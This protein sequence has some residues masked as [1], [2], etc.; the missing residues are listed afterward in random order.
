LPADDQHRWADHLTPPR[1]GAKQPR[2]GRGV[3]LAS[4]YGAGTG[5]WRG[6]DRSGLGR[7]GLRPAAGALRAAITK[8][9]RRLAPCFQ[10][11]RGVVRLHLIIHETGRVGRID[12]P[13]TAPPSVR[14]CVR[15][16]VR[17]WFFGP[18]IRSV[19]HRLTLRSMGEA[20]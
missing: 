4:S 18:L 2:L 6:Y 15:Q 17:R 10:R 14:H 13:G 16:H 3:E 5:S 7:E 9:A 20:Q 1:P 19:Q 8:R 12:T 11:A